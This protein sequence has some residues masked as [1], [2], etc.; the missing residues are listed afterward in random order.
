MRL[1]I[2]FL[3]KTIIPESI[4][5]SFQRARGL[6]VREKS[7]RHVRPEDVG[8]LLWRAAA[9]WRVPGR[10][11]VHGAEPEQP[12]EL[13]I[14]PWPEAARA[15]CLVEHPIPEGLVTI[16]EADDLLARPPRERTPVVQEDVDPVVSGEQQMQVGAEPQADPLGG[17]G[18]MGGSGP[19]RG[20]RP[21]DGPV[22]ERDEERLL[23][24][25]PIVDAAGQNARRP[26]DL[27]ERRGR[28]PLLPEQ[29]GGGI[30]EPGFVEGPERFLGHVTRK[31][32]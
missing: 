14:D 10:D 28:K 8:D 3:K 15:G 6:I 18:A 13:E 17:V 19:N 26:R 20:D 5:V 29:P 1:N 24:W 9:I 31:M 12:N 30:E 7:E 21:L 16:A 11:P 2:V 25:I 23:G 22:H 27:P 32:M 4:T